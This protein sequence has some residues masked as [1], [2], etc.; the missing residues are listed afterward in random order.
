MILLCGFLLPF[1]M[2]V[3][4]L[5]GYSAVYEDRRPHPLLH[6][7]KLAESALEATVSALIQS[8][9]M[10]FRHLKYWD[11]IITFASCTSSYASIAFCFCQ[12]DLRSGGL[13]GLP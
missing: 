5:C 13:Q 8:Y 1:Q 2:H 7:F 11:Y 9:A 4:F 3:L 12:V 6:C 10:I